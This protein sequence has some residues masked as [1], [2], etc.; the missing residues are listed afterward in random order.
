MAGDKRACQVGVVLLYWSGHRGRALERV[1][2]A[3]VHFSFSPLFYFN[4][5]K[6]I[7][8]RLRL[9]TL[10][11]YRT[12]SGDRGLLTIDT[13][14]VTDP[15]CETHNHKLSLL[16]RSPSRTRASHLSALGDGMWR[17]C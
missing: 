2:A 14:T 5:F 15:E 1:A 9:Q 16:S 13:N 8:T 4:S 7:L 12:G 17:R 11:S 10:T 6:E 3:D